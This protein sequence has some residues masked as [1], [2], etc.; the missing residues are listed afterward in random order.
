MKS[1]EVMCMLLAFVPTIADHGFLHKFIFHFKICN[2]NFLSFWTF[3]AHWLFFCPLSIIFSV[4]NSSLFFWTYLSCFSR[5]R[6]PYKLPPIKVLTCLSLDVP[7]FICT[8]PLP[9][10]PPAKNDGNQSPLIFVGT[11]WI[12]HFTVTVRKEAGV[13]LVLIHPFLLH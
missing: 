3:S 10:P 2:G 7:F 4:L 11:L 1:K 9:L 8:T 13:D 12:A 6:V 5:M